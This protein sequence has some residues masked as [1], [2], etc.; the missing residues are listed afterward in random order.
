MR[1]IGP[2]LSVIIG[3]F[4][5]HDAIEARSA[6]KSSRKVGE[7][8]FLEPVADVVWPME[9]EG[10]R[11]LGKKG[12]KRSG[13][14]H[15]GHKSKGYKH[16]GGSMH[17]AWHNYQYKGKGKG[18]HGHKGRGG[19][20]RRR[21]S[22]MKRYADFNSHMTKTSNKSNLNPPDPNGAAG[23]SSI[24]A[25]VN[26]EIEKQS[27]DGM[28]L[29]RMPL[30]EF[31]K[32][33]KESDSFTDPHVHYD[34]FDKI[35]WVILL[36]KTCD[37]D[38][39]PCS[40]AIL[41]AKSTTSDPGPDD[42]VFKRID[43]RL[44]DYYWN[45]YPGISF[46]RELLYL[47]SNIMPSDDNILPPGYTRTPLDKSYLWVLRKSNLKTHAGPI[48]LG[49]LQTNTP[50]VRH[51]GKRIGTYLVALKGSNNDQNTNDYLQAIRIGKVTNNPTGA[52][53]HYQEVK[54]DGLVGYDPNSNVKP[55][56]ALQLGAALDCST[57][58]I[59]TSHLWALD[60]VLHKKSL[61]VVFNLV[62]HRDGKNID[63]AIWVEVDVSNW[64]SLTVKQ[65]GKITG[66]NI[67]P[68]LYTYYPSIDINRNGVVGIGFS[69]S[70]Q[71]TFAGAYFTWRLPSDPIGTTRPVEKV[72][73]GQ[74]FYENL[75]DGRNRWGDYTSTAVD[76]KHENCFWVYNEFAAKLK[77]WATAWGQFCLVEVKL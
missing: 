25:V 64:W 53:I 65:Y 26:L 45:D 69:A 4:L 10:T 34:F 1:L 59:D 74:A 5:I 54:I 77:E 60:S 50:A 38:P 37:V 7:S 41:V 16:H 71:N 9:D 52:V 2:W 49:Q 62:V 70:S 24:I 27:R 57:G 72:R 13:K 47:T 6:E 23:P 68:Q 20:K 28:Q 35:F 12:G 8:D 46:D 19:T 76:P 43:T 56:T 55:N 51:A 32:S 14:K 15:M 67:A 39:P 18:K 30:E 44:Q 33:I 22:I 75:S 11:E 61:W 31:F 42:W 17:Y 58:C 63:T 29:W 73:E 48:S 36:E 3:L 66:D 40:S 21:I